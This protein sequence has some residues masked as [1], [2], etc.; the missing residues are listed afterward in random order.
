MMKSF[1]YSCLVNTYEQL[2]GA[3]EGT[4]ERAVNKLICPPP[5]AV[6]VLAAEDSKEKRC[7]RYKGVCCLHDVYSSVFFP[8]ANWPLFLQ[9]KH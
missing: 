2:L 6:H 3:K 4:R 8:E 7:V 5:R 1:T 9:H